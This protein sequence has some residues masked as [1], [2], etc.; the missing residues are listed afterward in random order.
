[1]YDALAVRKTTRGFD[2]MRALGLEQLALILYE[3]WGCHGTAP[4]IDE[5]FGL[6]RTSPSR[7]TG[8]PSPVP[9]AAPRQR[10]AWCQVFSDAL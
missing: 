3:V 8:G 7:I 5:L 4:I 9:I 2:R 1:M 10:S 6:R